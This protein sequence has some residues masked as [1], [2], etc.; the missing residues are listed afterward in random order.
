MEE[1]GVGEREVRDYFKEEGQMASADDDSNEK[2][3]IQ[4]EES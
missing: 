4:W 3:L 2:E 1:F